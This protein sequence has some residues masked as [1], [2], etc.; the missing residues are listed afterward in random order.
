MVLSPSG[1]G[2]PASETTVSHPKSM[3]VPVLLLTL[4]I[5]TGLVPAILLHIIS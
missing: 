4:S 5:I 3:V 1:D 2:Q